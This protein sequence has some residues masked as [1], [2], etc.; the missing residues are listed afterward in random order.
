MQMNKGSREANSQASNCISLAVGYFYCGLL[1]L[2]I[3]NNLRHMPTRQRMNQFK[4]VMINPGNCVILQFAH[5]VFSKPGVVPHRQKD[6]SLEIVLELHCL[7]EELFMHLI[8]LPR[9]RGERL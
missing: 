9:K 2:Q 7:T 1:L 4:K 6:K 8:L 3:A 5:M